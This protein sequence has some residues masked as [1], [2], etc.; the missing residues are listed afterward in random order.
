MGNGH[1]G[2][3]SDWEASRQASPFYLLGKLRSVHRPVE[4]PGER[5]VVAYKGVWSVRRWEKVN[6]EIKAP[7][8]LWLKG[9]HYVRL[10]VY[11]LFFFIFFP[12][13]QRQN[14]LWTNKI[15]S[16]CPSLLVHL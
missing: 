16:V 8:I 11:S 6:R 9:G 3:R 12:F 5:T 13:N 14:P 7:F 1:V 2:M 10:R 15:A 4:D